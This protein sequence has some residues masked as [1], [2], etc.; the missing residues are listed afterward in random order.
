MLQGLN[1]SHNHIGNK[2]VEAL[3]TALKYFDA[4]RVLDLQD[5]RVSDAGAM[6]LAT[7][8]SLSRDYGHDQSEAA[9]QASRASALAKLWLNSNQI[10][11]TGVK[12]LAEAIRV[13]NSL[14][15]LVLSYNKITDVGA[16]VL[17]EA[18]KACMHANCFCV[19]KLFFF[20]RLC[21]GY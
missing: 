15:T 17:A 10:G 13:N 6:H 20:D 14:R 2:G 7:L 5:N 4:L 18:I 19:F 8:L 16:T 11:D 21:F 3:S 9:A 12:A 1:L